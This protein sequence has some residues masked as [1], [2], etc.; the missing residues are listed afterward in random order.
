MSKQRIEDVINNV[1]NNDS[2]KYALDFVAYLRA[3]EI[4]LGESEN[5]WEVK[6]KGKC[7][8][9]IFING[10]DE[11]PGPWTIWSNQESGIWAAWADGDS[12]VEQESFP[13]DERTKEVAWANV[14]YCA[15]CG[16]NCSP[17]KRKTILGKEFD[18]VCSSAV[19]FTNPDS[20]AL[21]CAKKMVDI[22]KSEILKTIV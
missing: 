17:G 10:T 20:E 9:F 3:N 22:R 2:Q 7:V 18:N 4:P 15:S 14:N 1:L 11:K 21:D 16:S 13:V 19:A 12:G 6:Y 5:Y 8:C